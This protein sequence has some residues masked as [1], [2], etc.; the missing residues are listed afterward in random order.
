MSKF[1]NVF[2][3]YLKEDQVT[4]DPTKI[5][6]ALSKMSLPANV[7]QGL[8]D[9][10]GEIADAE[11][12]DPL[13][14]KVSKILDPDDKTD[15]TSLSDSE[16]TELLDRLKDKKV[17][18]ENAQNNNQQNPTQNAA[19]QQQQKSPTNASSATSYGV[20]SNNNSSKTQGGNLQGV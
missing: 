10:M 7:K 15:I 5:G 16:K 18:I 1:D 3:K 17:P 8:S 19:Q 20:S 14:A 11:N 12:T 6:D 2:K 4:F 13:H 9:T